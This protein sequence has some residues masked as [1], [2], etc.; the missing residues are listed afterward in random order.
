ML[1][2]FGAMTKRN[3]FAEINEVAQVLTP[4]PARLQPVGSIPVLSP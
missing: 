1:S 2:A 3:G 4:M